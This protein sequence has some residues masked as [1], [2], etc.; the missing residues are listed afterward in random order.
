MDLSP[1]GKRNRAAVISRLT[2]CLIPM[3]FG[4]EPLLWL[5]ATYSIAC[6]T[7]TSM[8]SQFDSLAYGTVS[9]KLTSIPASRK[10]LYAGKNNR[11]FEF[12]H[13]KTCTHLNISYIFL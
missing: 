3:T 9:F 5:L 11:Y 4:K 7:Y 1:L 10:T 8:R 6:A 13:L 2:R 12:K